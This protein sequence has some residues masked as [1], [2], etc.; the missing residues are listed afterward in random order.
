MSY[1]RL[2]L[3]HLYVSLSR[4][5]ELLCRNYEMISG[6]CDL[7]SRINNLV[8]HNVNWQQNDFDEILSINTNHILVII[9]KKTIGLLKKSYR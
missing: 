8:K 4:K 1:V 9:L 6:T 2:N 3:S 7:V 5:Y